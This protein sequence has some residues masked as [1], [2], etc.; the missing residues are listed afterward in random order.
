M[1]E[2]TLVL[3]KNELPQTSHVFLALIPV[4]L[5]KNLARRLSI[6]HTIF[7][8]VNPKLEEELDYIDH[9][10]NAKEYIGIG[11]ISYAFLGTILGYLIYWLS[12]QKERPINVA[13]SAGLGTFFVVTFFLTYF[14][15]KMPASTLKSNALSV[16]A[17][18]NYALKEL[19]LQ[20]KSGAGLFE[21]FVSIANSKYGAVTVAFDRMAREVNTGTPL[22]LALERM[23]KRQRSEYFRKAGWQLINTVKTGSE[24]ESTISPIIDEL[25]SY[26][27]TLIQNYSRELN[28]WSLVYM[29]FSVAIPT[30]GSTMLVILSVFAN[31][32]VGEGFFIGFAVAC[33]VIQ[34][35]MIFLVKSRRP[36]VSF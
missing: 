8:S 22:I 29:M 27:K 2:V 4:F 33:M 9:T 26:Q 14:L 23:V 6:I 28:L 21:S 18:L 7:L 13:I 25:D 12:L 16:D 19:V 31:M 1:T 30:I 3:S 11:F 34:V 10:L 32:G 20:S 24:I 35:I 17:S 5:I 36:N 15:V